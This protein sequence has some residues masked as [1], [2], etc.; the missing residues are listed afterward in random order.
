MPTLEGMHAPG[1]ENAHLL[2]PAG[3]INPIP[4]E[5][6]RFNRVVPHYPPD[7]CIHPHE[8]DVI[9]LPD[10]PAVMRNHPCMP[11]AGKDVRMQ[12][13]T[14]RFHKVYP[15]TDNIP[16]RSEGNNCVASAPITQSSTCPCTHR[17]PYAPSN[18]RRHF[19]YRYPSGP[20]TIQR[21][22]FAPD[23]C[24][25]V[26]PSHNLGHSM[27]VG[28]IQVNIPP[29]RQ[30]HPPPNNTPMAGWQGYASSG[31]AFGQATPPNQ[32]AVV[33]DITHGGDYV[34]SGRANPM[35]RNLLTTP[36]PNCVR[37]YNPAPYVCRPVYNRKYLLDCPTQDGPPADTYTFL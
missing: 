22:G 25:R 29:P 11:T 32:Y 8:G 13:D 27:A 19:D 23:A 37:P 2:P 16:C 20:T 5:V 9:C 18:P 6:Y 21:Q 7:P 30:Y 12:S 35:A 17:S 10:E 14:F 1:N 34:M 28:G 4:K 33:G 36:D 24:T 26:D 31:A 15:P 3:Y